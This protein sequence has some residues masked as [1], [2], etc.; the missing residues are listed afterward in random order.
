MFPYYYVAE[1]VSKRQ[2]I[3]K[4]STLISPSIQKICGQVSPEILNSRVKLYHI[5]EVA[6]ELDWE[7][8]APFI[9]LSDSECKEIRE[10][11]QGRYNLQRRAALQKWWIKNEN[12]A[13]YMRL[14]EILCSQNLVQQAEI[15]ASSLR[16]HVR[17]P[18]TS[19]VLDRF[20]Q[21]LHDCYTGPHPSFKKWPL[22]SNFPTIQTFFDLTF[23]SISS[24]D[25]HNKIR[26]LK[27]ADILTIKNKGILRILF[28]GVAGSGKTTLSWHACREWVEKRLLREFY[29][30]IHVQLNDLHVHEAT[31]L[32]DFIPELEQ[33][34]REEVASAIIDQEGEGTCF[35]FEGLD[36]APKV[37]LNTLFKLIEGNQ[38]PKLSYILTTRPNVDITR[39]ITKSVTA[40]FLI[41]GFSR[42]KLWAFMEASLGGQSEEY[43]LIEEKFKMNPQLESLC[44]VPL[45]AVIMSFL[46]QF[47]DEVPVTQGGLY[48]TLVIHF[49]KQYIQATTGS[50]PNIDCFPKDLE[51]Y[52]DTQH[53]FEQ[54][55]FLAFSA[56]QKKKQYFTVKELGHAGLKPNNTLGLLHIQSKITMFG[57]VRYYSFSHLSLQHFLGAVHLSQMSEQNQ[58][59]AIEISLKVDPLNSMIPFYA[60]LTHLSNRKALGVLSKILEERLDEMNTVAALKAKSGDPRHKALALFNCLYECQDESLFELPNIRLANCS[61]HETHPSNYTTR[62]EKLHE[63]SMRELGLTPPDCLALGYFMR[64]NSK[65]VKEKSLIQFDMGMCSDIGVRTFIKELRRDIDWYTPTRLQI[66]I[67]KCMLSKST[68][69]LLKDFLSGQSNVEDLELFEVFEPELI[70]LGLKSIIEGLNANSS[71]ISLYLH[72]CGINHTH[73]HLVILVLRFCQHLDKLGLIHA[74]LQWAM[75]LL[76]K[77]L[78]Y[79]TVRLLDLN[80]CDIN[81]TALIQ[82]GEGI[83]RNGFIKNLNLIGNCF[84]VSG[85]MKFLRLFINDE[86][87]LER[88]IIG[89][90]ICALLYKLK[91]FEVIILVI[92]HIKNRFFEVLSL[93]YIYERLVDT[94]GFGSRI[95]LNA[96]KLKSRQGVVLK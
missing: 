23:S 86:S 2:S 74:D 58:V 55:C 22:F 12:R 87:S 30:L 8:I 69:L 49:L 41:D 80:R 19:S 11:Y 6:R 88:L 85:M 67:R 31:Y 68:L 7:L 56:S 18:I 82:L 93:K 34:T 75:P 28:E 50:I 47:K 91:E 9:D 78:K 61:Y 16:S 95:V 27:L 73:V 51:N 43:K 71:C 40:H 90:E 29:F 42:E 64:T 33:E 39:R 52:Q 13:T 20:H 83:C 79:S 65:V 59:E 25:K 96:D 32:S 26:S 66:S 5:A 1:V 84:T 63:V 92:N 21:Y 48:K 4:F 53:Q 46:A 70:E 76:S 45:N 3:S 37:L 36:E 24:V 14:I 94:V 89:D 35:L 44:G 60:G 17:H 15:L 54:L 10:D 81:D 72:D 62:F 38:L 57:T 77:A